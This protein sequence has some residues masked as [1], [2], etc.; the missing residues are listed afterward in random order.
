M[1]KLQNELYNTLREIYPNGDSRFYNV[2][3]ELM[4]LYNNKQSDYATHEEPYRNFTKV[5]KNLEEYNIV[6]EGLSDIKTGL[7]YMS[8]QW[9]AILKM[10]GLNQIGKVE[11][12]SSKLK[13]VAVYSI[14]LSI[15]YEEKYN[16]IK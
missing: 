4:T 10:V 7:V 8:K 6:T 11:D 3:I 1:T 5:G 16:V 15:L 2:M 9:D 13:D 14:I 12:V